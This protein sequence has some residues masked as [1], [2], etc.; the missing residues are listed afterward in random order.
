MSC[1]IS[2]SRLVALAVVSAITAFP[3]HAADYPNRPIHVV[4]PWPPGGPTD[5]VARVISQEI[6]ETLRQPVVIDNKAG[7]TGVLGSDFVAKAAPDGYTIVVA[8][9]ASHSLAKIANSKMPYDPLK[10]FRPVIEYGRYPVA[11]F[12]GSQTPITN[13][14][15]FIAQARAAKDG[16]SIGLPGVGSVSHLYAQLLATKTGAKLT[17]VPYRGDAP[18]RL[19]LLSGNIHG[20]ASTPDFGLIADGKARLIGSTGTQRWPQTPNVPTFAEAGFPDL[21]GFIVWGFA[22]PAGTPDDIVKILNEATN[23]ALQSE[24]VKRVMVDN[25]YFVSGGTPDALWDVFAKQISEFGDVIRSGA[26]KFE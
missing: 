22:V 11:I 13:L 25:A 16:L 20:I 24:R 1:R 3:A 12:V 8:G 9:T 26:V 18:A 14:A 4:V 17:F 5:A 10:D 23:K 19:D 2:R 7:A 15:E 6:S 21:V